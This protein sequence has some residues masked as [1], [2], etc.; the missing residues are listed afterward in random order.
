MSNEQITH[1]KPPSQAMVIRP[2]AYLVALSSQE[3][4]RW[5]TL[6]GAVALTFIYLYM[7][8]ICS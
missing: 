8:D 5:L 3:C 1:K 7:S 2:F 6:G 4:G